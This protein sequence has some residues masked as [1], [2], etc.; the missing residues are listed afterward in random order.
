MLYP[1]TP[2]VIPLIGDKLDVSDLVPVVARYRVY[3]DTR[4][5]AVAQREFFP[6][7]S[8]AAPTRRHGAVALFAALSRRGGS[9][10]EAA[11]PLALHL[12][13]CAV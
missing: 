11:L 3:G 12:G 2:G 8:P 1:W 4:V 9:L 6:L 7:R 13:V 10:G 5:V